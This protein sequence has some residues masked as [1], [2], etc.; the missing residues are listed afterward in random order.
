MKAWTRWLCIPAACLLL[1]GCTDEHQDIQQWMNQATK[2]LKGRVKPL[3]EI[4]PSTIV[5]YTASS[6]VDPFNPS[7]LEPEKK[8]GKGL[9]PDLNRPKEPLEAF[10]LES[11]TMVGTLMMGKSVHAII[12]A[13]KTLY[14]VKVG[15]YMGQNFG[16]IT[17]ITESEVVLKELVQDSSGEYTERTSTLQLQEKQEAK[18]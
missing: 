7:R 16:R 17:K 14:Q 12:K 8:P 15:N 1:V 6:L 2:N 9:T 18:K 11:L 13:D 3:P 5:S 10:P 4:K